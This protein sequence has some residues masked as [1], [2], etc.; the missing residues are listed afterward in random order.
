[1]TCPKVHEIEFGTSKYRN[2]PVHTH[3]KYQTLQFPDP[4]LQIATS[5]QYL[6]AVETTLPHLKAK[7][8]HISR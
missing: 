8:R 5:S 7:K 3:L 2:L 6:L 4:N 1:M